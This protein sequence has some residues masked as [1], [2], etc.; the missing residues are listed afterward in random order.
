MAHVRQDVREH[1]RGGR[2]ADRLRGE[3][4]LARAML[5]VLGAH[6]PILPG[7]AGH[8]EDDHHRPDAARKEMGKGA[9]AQHR[10]EREDKENRRDRGEYVVQPLENVVDPAAV[11][12]GAGAKQ[13]AD[14]GSAERGQHT[15]R[16]RDLRALDRLVEHIAPPAVAT[17]GQRHRALG[18]GHLQL[19]GAPL[20]FGVFRRERVDRAQVGRHALVFCPLAQR[21]FEIRPLAEERR[22]GVG[23]ADLAAPAASEVAGGREKDH[24]QVGHD[25]AQ[26]YGTHPVLLQAAPERRPGVLGGNVEDR[27]HQRNWMRGSTNV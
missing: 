5:H 22:I 13:G 21:A 10:G 20:P 6:Q 9:A 11:E 24:H 19:A 26:R 25:D 15:H 4:I 2:G 17:P 3:H 1:A 27:R 16:D 14:D 8:R 23:H 12:T 7:P 18:L